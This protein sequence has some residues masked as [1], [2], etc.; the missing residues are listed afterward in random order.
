MELEFT[1]RI[2]EVVMLGTLESRYLSFERLLAT[3]IWMCNSIPEVLEL[4]MV[5]KSCVL[6][7]L[8]QTWNYKSRDDGLIRSRTQMEHINASSHFFPFVY[9]CSI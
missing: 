6:A 7:G 8:E 4:Y 9:K 3:H 1:S 5:E 2:A